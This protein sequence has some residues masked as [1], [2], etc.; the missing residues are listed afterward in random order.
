[1][2]A[3]KRLPVECAVLRVIIIEG[4]DSGMVFLLSGYAFA[5]HSK[6]VLQGI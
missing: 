2:S 4:E 3:G 1:M 6:R 5:S